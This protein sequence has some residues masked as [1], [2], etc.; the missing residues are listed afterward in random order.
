MNVF[1]DSSVFVAVFYQDHKFHKNSV[2][3]FER[4]SKDNASC[5]AHSIAEVYSTLTGVPGKDRTTRETALLYLQDIRARFNLVTLT[6]EEYLKGVER[7]ASVGVI[8]GGIYDSLIAQMALK[9]NAETIYTWNIKHFTR[10]GP[11]I[12]R[13]V[14]TP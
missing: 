1:L 4:C 11:E 12:A 8:G 2:D 7:T 14:A 10:L 9:A 5:A 6:A 3:L 13:R